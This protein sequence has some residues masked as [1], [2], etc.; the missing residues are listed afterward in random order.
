[1]ARPVGRGGYGY[2]YAIVCAL[3]VVGPLPAAA[4]QGDRLEIG[5]EQNR[6]STSAAS[7]GSGSAGSASRSCDA[8]ELESLFIRERSCVAC[9]GGQFSFGSFDYVLDDARLVK[10]FSSDTCPDGGLYRMVVPGDPTDSLVYERFVQMSEG[11]HAT[12][13]DLAAGLR[14]DASLGPDASLEIVWPTAAD[15]SMIFSWIVECLG[16]GRDAG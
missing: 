11:R 10:S 12:M 15:E 3:G 4:C 1:M 2:G 8:I 13:E 9:H 7:L 5:T 6:S 14:A 16:S